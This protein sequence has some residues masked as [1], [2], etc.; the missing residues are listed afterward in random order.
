VSAAFSRDAAE[1]CGSCARWSQEHVYTLNPD[2]GECL[3]IE[4]VWDWRL[5]NDKDVT[6]VD[7]ALMMD[8]NAILLTHRTFGCTRWESR[9]PTETPRSE[10]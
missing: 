6:A 8:R 10:S 9:R 5:D 1:R 7:G 3:G 4:P 2:S